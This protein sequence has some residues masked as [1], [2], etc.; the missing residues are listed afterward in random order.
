MRF[1][2]NTFNYIIQNLIIWFICS[3]Q[4][5]AW[6]YVSEEGEAGTLNFL[7]QEPNILRTTPFKASQLVTSVWAEK[8]TSTQDELLLCNS[9]TERMLGSSFPSC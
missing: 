7:G 3:P 1:L 2:I 5:V 6:P 9:S 8:I 4:S